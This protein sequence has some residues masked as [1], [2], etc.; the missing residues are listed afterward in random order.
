MWFVVDS[1]SWYA[2]LRGRWRGSCDW[3]RREE[4][5]TLSTTVANRWL[6]A[7]LYMGSLHEV[8]RKVSAWVRNP[9]TAL[10]KKLE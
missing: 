8:S 7:S 1:G 9:D 5:T 4:S 10:T 6:G 3:N 2:G